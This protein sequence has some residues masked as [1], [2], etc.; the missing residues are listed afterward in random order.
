MYL[1]LLYAFFVLLLQQEHE[2]DLKEERSRA[3]ELEREV[4]RLVTRKEELKEQLRSC[5]DELTQVKE[6][7]R[8]TLL[9]Y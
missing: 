4:D 1:C 9:R 5:E 3:T 6:S 2:R 7:H 8:Y